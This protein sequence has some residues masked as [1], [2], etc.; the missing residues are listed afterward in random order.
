M[1]GPNYVGN[2]FFGD[3][4]F[5]VLDG[6]GYQIYKSTVGNFV[7]ARG[8][9]A[10]S[11]ERYEK[12]AE[13]KPVAGADT[14]PHM[15]NF[16]EA[17]KSRDHTKLTAD[18]EIG[19]RSAAFCHLANIAYRTGRVLKLDANGRFINDDEANAMQ[20]RDYRTPYVVPEQV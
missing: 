14:V 20:T 19:A 8:A 10:G 6:G 2:I 12:V 7:G 11:K 16:I 17:M 1:R 5:M 13:E 4:G 3:L 15:R 9:G 18:I